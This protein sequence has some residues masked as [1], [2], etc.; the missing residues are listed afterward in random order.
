VIEHYE[1]PEFWF[2]SDNGSYEGEFYAL[3][4]AAELDFNISENRTMPLD[5][6]HPTHTQ[7]ICLA[8]MEDGWSVPEEDLT[9]ESEASSL[10]CRARGEGET[11][12]I[13]Y[14]Y[15]TRAAEVEPGGVADYLSDLR[16][17]NE[18]LAYGVTTGIGGADAGLFS[19]TEINWPILMLQMALIAV[20]VWLALRVWR[21]RGP[22]PRTDPLHPPLAAPS[23]GGWL[24]LLAFGMVIQPLVILVAS[25]SALDVY[26][27]SS[28]SDLATPGNANY[29]P[30]W[31][32]LL[33]FE[34]ATNTFM[35]VFSVLLAI[36]FF[37][38]RSGFPRLFIAVEWGFIVVAAIDTLASRA[39]PVVGEIG[40]E[41]ITDLVRQIVW[42][43]IWS[44]YL[45]KSRRAQATFVR[46]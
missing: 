20:A 1:V 23:I 17:M 44:L 24:V 33:I 40:A 18:L 11:L 36:C 6:D 3:E 15:K 4:I 43:T 10:R 39:L 16:E 34:Q 35:V 14:V 26:A 12:R 32:P 31:A 13:E 8:D 42:A 21:R 9:I 19:A 28:W 38:R 30:L 22:D 41:E 25:L 27:M 29:H 46:P 37:S 2:E 45:L 7:Y 5:V